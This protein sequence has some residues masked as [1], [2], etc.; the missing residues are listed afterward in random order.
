VLLVHALVHFFS[1]FPSIKFCYCRHI[2]VLD[3]VYVTEYTAHDV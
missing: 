1:Y 2:L 3:R